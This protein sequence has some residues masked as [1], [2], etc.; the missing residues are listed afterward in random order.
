MNNRSITA[1]WKAIR[2]QLETLCKR[3]YFREAPENKTFPYIVFDVRNATD[4]RIILELDLWGVRDEEVTLQTLADDLEELIDG[5]VL[6]ESLF[7]ASLY[8]N[9]DL[10][11]VADENKDIK[12]I[13]MSFTATY[14]G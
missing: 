11:W 12:H 5:M 1:F 14:Q 13:N 8:S 6:S 9:N 3:V 10:K 2:A 4:I 7:M